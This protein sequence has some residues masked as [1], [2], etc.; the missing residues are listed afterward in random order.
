MNVSLK[1]REFEWKYTLY[2]TTEP[3]PLCFSAM[4]MSN[5]CNLKYVARDPY[6]CGTEL[7]DKSKFIAIRKINITGLLKIWK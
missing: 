5:I 7:N 4:V 2:S 6:A 1:V 3:C